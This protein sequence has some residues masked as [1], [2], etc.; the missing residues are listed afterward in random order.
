MHDDS[1]GPWGSRRTAPFLTRQHVLRVPDPRSMPQKRGPLLHMWQLY[2]DLKKLTGRVHLHFSA[3][4]E[5]LAYPTCRSQQASPM[6]MA[7]SCIHISDSWTVR[8]AVLTCY[9]STHNKYIS[10]NASRFGELGSGP[11]LNVC[12]H[13][14]LPQLRQ[15]CTITGNGT[16]KLAE[17]LLHA[18][19]NKFRLTSL[20]WLMRWS[21]R[22]PDVSSQS[23]VSS[24][25]FIQA[26]H[27][28]PR[29]ASE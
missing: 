12:E 22:L 29:I 14:H 15:A 5:P 20:S 2:S 17:E 27:R 24:S 7:N 9:I 28:W 16:V 13:S 21:A 26:R 25:V 23:C 19:F 18:M 8:P 10:H 4:E 6:C 11:A 1:L 3:S